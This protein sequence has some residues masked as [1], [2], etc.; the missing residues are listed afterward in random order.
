[1]GDTKSVKIGE[2]I[3]LTKDHSCMNYTFYAGQLVRV[4]EDG[5]YGYT[6]MDGIGRTMSDCGHDL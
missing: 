2:L 3:V 1:M 5:P 6:I 4:I